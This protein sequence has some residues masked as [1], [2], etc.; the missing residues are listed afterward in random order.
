MNYAAWLGDDTVAIF[1]LH[2]VVAAP[3]RPLRN[4]TRKHL[5][6]DYFAA[7]LNEL[8]AAGGAPISLDDYVAHAKER[9]Q[10]PRRAFAVTFDDG[11]ENNLSVAAPVLAELKIPTTFYITTRFV[12]ENL[13]SWID[14]IE[15]ALE[16]ADP[17]MLMLPWGEMRFGDLASKRSILDTVR[18]RVKTDRTIDMD[19]LATEVQ[20]QL[21]LSPIWSGDD[22]LDR[23]L[24][25][26]DVRSLAGDP[27]FTVGGHTH[28]HAIMSYLDDAQ[29]AFE[30][31][32]SLRLLRDQAGIRTSHYSYPE[33]L[34][35][36][37]SDRVIEALC[38]RGIVCSPTAEAGTNPPEADLFRLRRIMVT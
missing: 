38:G 30:I 13:M 12:D 19:A 5:Q 4:Y 16:P 9:A 7:F 15:Y 1:L 34:A 23:K 8:L 21:G 37:Y 36:C 33:G 31:D 18:A 26:G 17:G 25:W 32:T 3:V 24:S 35:H 28:T 22:P 27:L 10:L 14:R 20:R 11:F 2:G 29:L 6:M